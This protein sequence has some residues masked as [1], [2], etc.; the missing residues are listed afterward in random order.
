[1]LTDASPEFELLVRCVRHD[2]VEADDRLNAVLD[3][4]PDWERVLELSRRHGVTPLLNRGVRELESSDGAVDV[5]DRVRSALTERT[6]STAMRNVRLATELHEL[7]GAFEERGVRALPFKGPM[8]EAFAYGEVGMRAYRDLDVLVP[9]EDVTDALDVLEA[10]GYDWTDAPRL[11]DSPILGGPFTMPLVPECELQRDQVRVEI[12]WRVGDP[13]QPFSPDVKTLWDR[14]ETLTVAGS[15][16]PTLTPEDRLRM[17][18]F[19]GTKHKW[20]LLKWACDFAAALE[21]SDLNWQPVFEETRRHGDERRLL[22]GIALIDQ[23]FE[24]TVSEPVR[25]RLADDPRAN[26]LAAAAVEE[27]CSETTGRP[28][29]RDKLAYTARAT[30]SI[31]DALRTVL[32]HSGLHPGLMEYRLLPLPGYVHPIYYLLFPLRYL[33]ERTGIWE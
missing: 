6:R 5:P 13:D 16:V 21:A 1:M 8:L 20:H 19:H 12:R 29:R 32:F 23:L 27:M 3:R 11:D 24:T 17:L 10:R 14:R 30:D 2:G 15:D 33:A 28:E 22:I 18:A 9:R 31:G 26:R 4:N 7:M 25:E